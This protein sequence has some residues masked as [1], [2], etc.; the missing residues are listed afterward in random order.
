MKIEPKRLSQKRFC[1]H[2]QCTNAKIAADL[3]ICGYLFR[4]SLAQALP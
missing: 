4:R 1:M 3:L 2:L